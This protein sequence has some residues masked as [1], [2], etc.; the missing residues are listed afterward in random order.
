[1]LRS[2]LFFSIW[3]M[4]AKES[5]IPWMKTNVSSSEIANRT[6]SKCLFLIARVH[7]LSMNGWLTLWPSAYA[8]LLHGDCSRSQTFSMAEGCCSAPFEHD[9][10]HSPLNLVTS[11][12]ASQY[13]THP[14][15][16]L[17]IFVRWFLGA[18]GK[19]VKFDSSHFFLIIS[20]FQIKFCPTWL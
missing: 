10:F 14:T 18:F 13:D 8:C 16:C 20:F 12:Q 1:M 9:G 3:V 2:L 6:F 5:I 11:W 7:A 15:E 17:F 19:F 4:T